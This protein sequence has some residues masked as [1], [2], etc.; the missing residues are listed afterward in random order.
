MWRQH[1]SRP[2]PSSKSTNSRLYVVYYTL[3]KKKRCLFQLAQSFK[4]IKAK[5]VATIQKMSADI[6]KKAQ[7]VGDDEAKQ[8][9]VDACES[10]KDIPQVRTFGPRVSPSLIVS[11]RSDQRSLLQK[12]P[13]SSSLVKSSWK[14]LQRVCSKLPPLTH[15]NAGMRPCLRAYIMSVTTPCTGCMVYQGWIPVGTL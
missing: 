5:G 6:A 1:A 14:E 10:L 12:P 3:G 15:K 8:E 7:E 11:F 9:F 4:E 13:N 2:H